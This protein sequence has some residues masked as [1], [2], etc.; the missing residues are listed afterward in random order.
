MKPLFEQPVPLLACLLPA[1]LITLG[2]VTL[3]ERHFRLQPGAALLNARSMPTAPRQAQT[4]RH[5]GLPSVL[6]VCTLD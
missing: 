6:T 2:L 5:Q 4:A 1:A 3:A